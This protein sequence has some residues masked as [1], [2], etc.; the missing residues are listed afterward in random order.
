MDDVFLAPPF[1][2]RSEIQRASHDLVRGQGNIEGDGRSIWPAWKQAFCREDIIC[3]FTVS[4]IRDVYN[5]QA[6]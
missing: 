1:Q 4:F 3:L 2:S 6:Y 5:G